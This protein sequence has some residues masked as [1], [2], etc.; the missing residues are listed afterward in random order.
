MHSPR[1]HF[2]NARQT[3]SA[4]QDII[5]STLLQTWQQ[6]CDHLS[7]DA[8]DVVIKAGHYVLEGKGCLGYC[9]EPGLI[10]LTVDPLSHDLTSATL[11]R[12]FA[13]ELHHAARWDGPGYGITPGEALV[14][15]GLA[16]HFALQVCGG[17]AEPWETVNLSTLRPGIERAAREW[18]QPGYDHAAWFFGTADLPRWCGYSLGFALIAHWLRQHPQHT[19]ASLAQAEASPFR[20]SLLA[21]LSA[22]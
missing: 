18:S 15:E 13:H 10:Y 17:E 21:L 9:P 7:L 6:A 19:A 1:L 22:Q 12:M 8:V 3:L 20:D 4:Q 5:T 11:S 16:G 2:M 14:S